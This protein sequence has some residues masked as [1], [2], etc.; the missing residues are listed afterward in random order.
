MGCIW[1]VGCVVVGVVIGVGVCYCVY[2]LVWGRD[3]NEKIWDEDE[4]FMDI[5]EIGVEIV[6][7]VKINVGVGFGVKF[8]G[9]LKVKFEVSLGF[10][11]CLGVKEKV[12]LGFYSGGGLEVKVKVFFN[13]LKEQVS[14]KVGKGV[15]VGIIFGNRIFV[16][17]LF[18]LGGR[19]G[20]C[21]FIR[22]GFRVGSRVSGKFKGK[23]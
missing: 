14:V 19:G 2:R 9:D 5:L 13:M 1:E 8:Q 11:D 18:C 12:Y 21:Y 7:G 10:E 22:S 15:R 17:S 23:V 4:E 3:E 6:K 16:L 20:G